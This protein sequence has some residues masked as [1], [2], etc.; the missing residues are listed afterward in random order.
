MNNNNYFTEKKKK[1]KIILS[2][3]GITQPQYQKALLL[4][5]K[6]E[7]EELKYNLQNNNYNNTFN[8]NYKLNNSELNF[9]NAEENIRKQFEE[10]E[11]IRRI[12]YLEEQ[13]QRRLEYEN[14]LQSLE[15]N[16]INALD[17]MGLGP[18]YNSNELKNSYKRLSIQ[19]HPDRPNGNKDKFQLITK[20][21]MYLLERLN[22]IETENKGFTDLKNGFSK[23]IDNNNE[24]EDRMREQLKSMF[25]PQKSNNNRY[26]DINNNSSTYLDPK[27]QGFNSA[28]FNKLYQENKLWDPNDDGYDDWFRNGPDNEDDKPELFGDKFNLNIFNSTFNNYK[29]KNKHSNSIIK[30]DEPNE[31]VS[32]MTAFTEID[33]TRP[34]EDFS[35]PTDAPGSLQYT[36]LKKAYTGGYNFINP[37]NVD[38]RKE[39]R[40][41]E[42]L[43]KERSNVNYIMTSHEK[44]IYDARQIE[45]V[46][47]EKQ[48]IERLR[49][50]DMIQR[51]HY[52]QTHQSMLGYSGNPDL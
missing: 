17:I 47:E 2:T 29:S 11:R 10:Q 20:C 1:I 45:K 49:Q 38:S 24:T 7:Q 25:V 22:S 4:L 51:D 5:Q 26:N 34:I 39:Y 32:A 40:N 3:P 35:K 9:T 23:Y 44:A 42:D 48:R 18:N 52:R 43:Q 14:K 50:L 8:N 41:I 36:D 16:N 30:Y 37:D 27:T 13:K 31:M 21:Y 15:N 6:I 12:K 46:A 28:L 19:F 33:N